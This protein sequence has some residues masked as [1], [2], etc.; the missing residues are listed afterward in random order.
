MTRVDA[1]TWTFTTTG[2]HHAALYR[3]AGSQRDSQHYYGQFVVPFS[4]TARAINSQTVPSPTI[5]AINVSLTPPELAITNPTGDQTLPAGSDVT[6]EA[7]A[8]DHCLDISEEVM[9]T[10]NDQPAVTGSSWV[11]TF[12]E[13]GTY[14]VVATALNRSGVYA[15]DRVVITIGNPPS[16]DTMSVDALSWK[17]PRR[18][19]DVQ[20]VITIMDPV[21]NPVPGVDVTGSLGNP[22]GGVSESISATTNSSGQVTKTIKD[23]PAGEWCVSITDVQD[24][25][26]TYSWDAVQPAPNCITKN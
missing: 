4:G 6:F 19:R 11:T 3:Y 13:E 14:D 12:T 5:P 24:P 15:T 17:F 18:G 22:A 1:D 7:L 16:G 25:A 2:Q 23:A 20:V 8:Y 9:W 26:G 10:I 21:G